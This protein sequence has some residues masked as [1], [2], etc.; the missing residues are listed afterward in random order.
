MDI[1]LMSSVA[2]AIDEINTLSLS[3]WEPLAGMKTACG[4]LSLNE[5]DRSLTLCE[6]VLQRLG[7]ER[8]LY[9]GGKGEHCRFLCCFFFVCL[10]G[11]FLF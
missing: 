5:R 3:C 10:V 2:I 4:E 7:K 6:D 9:L 11:I 8:G 1:S